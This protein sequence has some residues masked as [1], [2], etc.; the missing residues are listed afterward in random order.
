VSHRDTELGQ[1]RPLGRSGERWRR[2][3]YAQPLYLRTPPT[4]VVGVGVYEIRVLVM[5]G[6]HREQFV[7]AEVAND[8][9]M[10]VTRIWIELLRHANGRPRFTSRG[11]L[12][13]TRLGGPDGEMLCE[14]TVL[15]A[16]S[17]CRA[18]LARGIS[19][20]FETWKEG[21]PYAC[22]RGDI[23]KAAGL[24][25][26]E[27]DTPGR[28]CKP[29]FTRWQPYPSAQDAVSQRAVK[30]PASENDGTVGES[31]PTRTPLYGRTRR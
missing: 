30:A 26:S 2:G 14:R 31:L 5:R 23:E 22:M 27:P 24:T 13:R 12:Y 29:M 20:P 18:L 28:D 9:R 19:G 3:R 7:G 15:P 4:K 11:Q 1:P 25:V 10:V 17:S 6:S 21:V 8:K 16:C